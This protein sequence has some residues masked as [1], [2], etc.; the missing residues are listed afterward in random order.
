MKRQV[1]LILKK[2]PSL[3]V[4]AESIN[5]INVTAKSIPEIENLILWNGKRQE[6]VGD[7]FEVRIT[8]LAETEK[9][10]KLD[11]KGIGVVSNAQGGLDK[12]VVQGDLSRFKR[13]GQG[14]TAGEMVILGSV[15]F[16]AGALM[17]GGKLLIH[18]NAGDWLGA[19]MEGG[20]IRVEGSAGHFVGS[21]YRGKSKGMTGGMILIR[22]QA[23]Q[24]AGARMRR[25][26]IVIGGDC[27]D[28]PGFG[29]LAGT[30]VI[31]GSA[32]IRV[33][34]KMQRGTVILLQP[35]SLL[36][37]FYYNCT[38]R[39][40]FWGLLYTYLVQE[41]FE[42][43]AAFKDALFRRYSGDAI[44]GGK[45]EILICQSHSTTTMT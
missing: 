25:G 3:P 20:Q 40:P 31:A 7:Y 43:P 32:G 24:M 42:L 5:P 44:E 8:P 36:P 4:E 13:L 22:D 21:A 11:E 15:G 23:G 10:V 28:M 17:R 39:P 26:L 35:N 2:Q 12:L 37:T 41:G 18:G 14:M 1:T 6:K 29:M 33:G 19:H 27:G 45:G 30:I 9:D 34:A 38:F 16:H